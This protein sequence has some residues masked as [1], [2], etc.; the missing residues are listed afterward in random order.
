[1]KGSLSKCFQIYN[2]PSVVTYRSDLII[3]VIY[4]S[5]RLLFSSQNFK[6]AISYCLYLWVI[7]FF[8]HEKK[9]CDTFLRKD[10][11]K[12]DSGP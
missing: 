8:E 4:V 5:V 6:N 2:L 7:H 1:M 3:E 10:L 9:I 11:S 12:V